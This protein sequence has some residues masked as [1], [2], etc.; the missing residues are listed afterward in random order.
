MTRIELCTEGLTP[1]A[2]EA[3]LDVI[4]QELR[5]S[6]GEV[7]A[8]G[9]FELDLVACDEGADNAP[10]LRINGLPFGQVDAVRAR[11][12]IRGNKRRSS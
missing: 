5:I 10:H 2:R 11:E 1:D 7:S 9:N 12:I 8:D 4:Y 6:P 3:I